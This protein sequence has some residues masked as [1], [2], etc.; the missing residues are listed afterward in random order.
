MGKSSLGTLVGFGVAL[1]FAGCNTPAAGHDAGALRDAPPAPFDAGPPNP[2]VGMVGIGTTYVRMVNLIPAGPN[3]TVCLATIPGTGIAPTPAHI[4]GQPDPSIPSDGTLPYPGV[5]PYLPAPIYDVPGFGYELRLYNRA[6]LPFSSLARCPDVGQSPAP[7]ITARIMAADVMVDH[8]YS[9]TIIGVLPGTPVTCPG[10]CPEV[11]TRM[12]EDSLTPPAGNSVRVRLFQGVPNLPGPIHVCF[13]LDYSAGGDGPIP[14]SRSLPPAADTDGLAF[15]EV[16][17][18]IPIPP[19][20]TVG[21]FYTHLN[22][23]GVP[24]CDPSTR[25]LG[26]TTVPLPVPATAPVDV[27]RVFAAHD[28]IT[29]FAFGRVGSACTTA[30]D[31][32][33]PSS[34]CTTDTPCTCDPTGHCADALAGNLL[35]WR[36][37]RGDAPRPDAGTDA[38]TD[39]GM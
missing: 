19:V 21:A 25:L 6:D 36:D 20:T 12:F 14:P 10:N 17:P 2:D 37:V 1:A 34:V 22:V 39:A 35:P 24:D 29:N 5:S 30:A 16:T 33:A 4:I 18:Y 31:C 28:V 38:G 23:A 8:H 3:L 11:Q 15:G 7:V 27:A 9:L 26:P 32:V 13:D